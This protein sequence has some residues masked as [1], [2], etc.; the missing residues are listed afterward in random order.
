MSN[1]SINSILNTLSEKE[2]KYA[3]E[4][5]KEY[6]D[7]GSSETYNNLIYED[8]EEVP[9]DITEFLHN[10]IYLGKAL[11]NEEGK[12][13]IFP[14]WEKVLCQIFPTNIDTTYNTAVFTG[15][16]GLGKSTIAV[17]AILYQLYRMMCLKNPYIHYGIQE[18]D[19]IT[20][21]FM[22]I[23]LDAAKGVAW[24]KCQ[25]MLKRSQWFLERG[26]LGRQTDPQ[27]Q[28]PKGIELIIG[29]EPSHI[30]GRAVFGF[31]ADEV[32]F[33]KGQDI[34]K[35][36]R[37]AAEIINSA[38]ARM[39]SRFMKGEKNPTIMLIAS[40]KR[41]EQ[42]YLESF[43]A[44]KKKNNSKT[45]LI[46]D[47]PQ[48]IIRTDK[49]SPNKFW[50]AIGNKFLNSEVLPLNISEN[51]LKIYRDKGYRLMQ[52]PMGYREAFEDDLDTAL[53]D[54]AGI[55]TTNSSKFINGSRLL[56]I[57][58]YTLRNPFTKDIIEV[59]N[60]PTDKTQY[61]DFFDM[62]NIPDKLKSM[63]LFIHMDL[64]VSGDKTG[65]AGTWI[66]GK[67]PS[68]EGVSQSK[69]MYYQLA[70]SVAVKAPKGY[71][72]S[73]EKNRQFIYWLKKQGFKIKGISTDS[74]QSTDTGQLLKQNGFDYKMIS[75]DRV[76]QASHVCVPYQ[77]LKSTIY[78]ERIRMYDSTVLTD[79][80][81][82]IE[83]DSNG[84]VD[85]TPDFHKDIADALAGSVYNASQ[86]AEQFA[87]DYGEDMS[88]IDNINK[89][90]DFAVNKEQITMDFEEALK[91][92]QD[93]LGLNN[94][95]KSNNTIN[96][97]SI[98][99][100]EQQYCNIADGILLW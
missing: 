6:S 27:W 47:E 94:L 17:I 71:Q 7:K 46:I 76:D 5:L 91:G 86:Y 54:I 22:N 20:F 52:V 79:E 15:A 37:K 36:K 99:S 58:D 39:Q 10:P 60:A 13:T 85:H 18:T 73:F 2:R 11:T 97:N 67:K 19:L 93:P 4:I 29:S 75:V 1:D 80:L 28:P 24:N 41:T 69:E 30:I 12:F 31:F 16:I 89:N 56:T 50:L 3:L 74:F 48:W 40:S 63:P 62:N 43:I 34:E 33:K 81:L 8:Y 21:A 87:Y 26:T 57:K 45:T 77:Y 65:I 42:S 9:V 44:N 32:S 83:K 59:G 70:F 14:Y 64:S 84:K 98:M 38:S 53:T 23:T 92:I 25:Q 95:Q 78:E 55:S 90:N 100:M 51:D 61:W 88:L 66:I 68:Q 49:D 72:I 35:Q 82:N 96:K